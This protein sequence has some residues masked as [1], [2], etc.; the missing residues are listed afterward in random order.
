MIEKQQCDEGIKKT[1][2]PLMKDIATLSTKTMCAFEQEG[3]ALTFRDFNALEE[4]LGECKF[5]PFR[6][7]GD[8]L[9]VWRYEIT[10]GHG[11]LILNSKIYLHIFD[12]CSWTGSQQ[13]IDKHFEKQHHCEPFKYFDHGI[14][15]YQPNKKN[16]YINLINAFNKKFVLHY[17]SD[18]DEPS[19]MFIIYLIGRKCDAQKYVIDFELKLDHRKVKFV[20]DCHCDADAQESME[21]EQCF[22]IS[23]KLFATYATDGRVKFRFVI[24]RKDLMDEE[25]RAQEQHSLNKG[26]GNNMAKAGRTFSTPSVSSA[27][28]AEAYSRIADIKKASARANARRFSQK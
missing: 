3:C 2:N 27:K 10:I 9:N 20:D 13:D 16:Q 11:H 17:R 25:E 5:R 7:I 4:H 26:Y 23:K 22:V 6:C 18:V 21:K 28:Y 8:I 12:R 15:D 24:K 1:T 14:V 19:V